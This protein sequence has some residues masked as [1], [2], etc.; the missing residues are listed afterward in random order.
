MA[1]QALEAEQD[2]DAIDLYEQLA[3]ADIQ[4]T[5]DILAPIYAQTDRRD[6]YVSL[7]VAPYLAND[8]EQTL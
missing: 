2:R 5:A 1:I 4:A 3:I 7:E 8:L 6:G